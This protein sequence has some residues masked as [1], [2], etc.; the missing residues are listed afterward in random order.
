MNSSFFLFLGLFISVNAQA[1][2][3]EYASKEHELPQSCKLTFSAEVNGKIYDAICTASFIGNKTFSTAE[4][5][6]KYINDHLMLLES[7]KVK[8]AP[9]FECPG[10]K[11]KIFVK[12]T[13][14]I[15]DAR[16]SEG[17]D[18]ALMKVDDEVP[19]IKPLSLPKTKGEVEDLLKDPKKCYVNGYGRDNEGKSGTLRAIQ[20]VE[21]D[22]RPFGVPG[23]TTQSFKL[24]KN[25]AQSGDSGGPMYCYDGERPVLVGVVHG[26][27][28]DEDYSIIEKITEGL[29]WMYFVKDNPSPEIQD[30]RSFIRM[31]DK[32]AAVIECF[33]KL[34]S[35]AALSQDLKNILKVLTTDLQKMK[36][37]LSQ[38]KGLDMKQIDSTWEAFDSEWE[39]QNCYEVLYP[40]KK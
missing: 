15:K 17:F 39:K 16:L 38:G 14:P 21:W 31:E 3:G 7:K 9:Y 19:E 18:L 28:G 33:N 20:V 5:C 32:C 4:H 37:Q 22:A 29:D 8:E 25:Y 23:V 12:E 26:G 24:M 34:E 1:V 6:E 2:K 27:R 36:F 35:A 10:I 13:F 30:F 11:R 40:S